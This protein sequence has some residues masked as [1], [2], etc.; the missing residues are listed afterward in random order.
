[1]KS[2]FGRRAGSGA[3]AQPAVAVAVRAAAR[4]ILSSVLMIRS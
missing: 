2:T 1:M 4:R 3:V